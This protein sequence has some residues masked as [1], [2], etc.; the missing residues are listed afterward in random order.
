MNNTRKSPNYLHSIQC[1]WISSAPFSDEAKM[2]LVLYQVSLD[3]RDV[4]P[5]YL[6]S[7]RSIPFTVSW[8]VFLSLFVFMSVYTLFLWSWLPDLLVDNSLLL[9]APLCSVFLCS[10]ST[11]WLAIWLWPVKSFWFFLICVVSIV[12]Y[13]AENLLSNVFLSL[14]FMSL[15]DADKDFQKKKINLRQ[16]NSLV[17]HLWILG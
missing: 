12:Q 11:S 6:L 14:Y 13:L 9:E 1:S 10:I 8:S 4:V 5:E 15:Y 17:L 3:P 16:F 2:T 7:Y